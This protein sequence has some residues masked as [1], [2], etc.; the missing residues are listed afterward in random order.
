M[1]KIL[2]KVF[3]LLSLCLMMSCK[4]EVTNPNSKFTVSGKAIY[5]DNPLAGAE[6]SLNK[7]LNYSTTTDSEGNFEITNVPSGNYNLTISKNFSDG[8]FTEISEDIAVTDNLN[9]SELKLPKAVLLYPITEITSSSVKL[10]WTPTDASDFREYKIYRHTTPGLD[11]TTGTLIYVATSI[12]DTS[13]I[14]SELFESTTYYYRIYV[15]NDFGRLGGSNINSAKT[16]FKNLIKN[17]DFES[18]NSSSE[19]TDW[20]LENDVWFVS[21]QNY[22]SGAYGLRGERNSYLVEL[23]PGASLRQ[24]IP[25]PSIV[26]GKQYTFSYNY[27]VEDLAGNSTLKV[28]IGTSVQSGYDIYY[29]FIDGTNSNGWETKS[30]TFTAPVL[31]ED[32]VVSCYVEVNIPYNNEPWLMWLDNFE[33]KRTE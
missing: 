4:E 27:Y 28:A 11:E 10:T 22:Q 26:P 24:F 8:K 25:Y 6:V 15:M 13:F 32:L 2:L 14:D 23:G 33:L 17:G 18:F 12:N 19:P 9:L 20:L 3:L 7:T 1:K 21:N 29:Y 30:F 16:L 5:N 31:T